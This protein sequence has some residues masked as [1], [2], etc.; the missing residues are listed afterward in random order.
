MNNNITTN[1]SLYRN[2]MANLLNQYL[3]N[4]AV[5]ITK[6]YNYHWN[7]VD[8]LFIL[9]HDKTKEYYTKMQEIY[10]EVAERIKMLNGY[11]ITTLE[12][13]SKISTIKSVESK[14]YDR[15]TI[16]RSIISDFEILLSIVQEIGDIATQVNDMNTINLVTMYTTFF[17]KQLWMLRAQLNKYYIPY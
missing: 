11:P 10:D 17:E 6:L 2:N 7:V 12:E 5:I 4:I 14:D 16:I 3:S 15:N 13:Y 1:S 8:D 9:I